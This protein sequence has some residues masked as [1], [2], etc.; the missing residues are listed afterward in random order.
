MKNII[1]NSHDDNNLEQSFLPKSF[2]MF[3]CGI[4]CGPV[5]VGVIGE[6]KFIYDLWGDT[7]NIASRME[8]HGKIGEI[9]VTE[10]FKNAIENTDLKNIENNS[11]GNGVQSDFIFIEREV[12]EVKGVG[13]MKTFFLNKNPES[14]QEH[15]YEDVEYFNSF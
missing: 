7:V 8:S 15:K 11:L 4:D 3:R 5:V 10:R 9:Q 12:I 14:I 1:V 13:K 2:L 6:K